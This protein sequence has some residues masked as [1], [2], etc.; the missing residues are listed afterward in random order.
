MRWG[1]VE[2]VSKSLFFGLLITISL[3][4]A[5]HFLDF[6]VLKHESD[7]PLTLVQRT[8]AAWVYRWPNILWRELLAR[9]VALAATGLTN[10]AL[11]TSLIYALKVR[12][13]P[14]RRFR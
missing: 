4:L 3:V 12:R 6:F 1:H 13:E 2:R 5:V 9:E 11:Y 7:S 14:R 10:V 8:P